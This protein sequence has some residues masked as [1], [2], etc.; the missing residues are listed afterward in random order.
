MEAS[1]R[2]YVIVYLYTLVKHVAVCFHGDRDS[3]GG[4]YKAG[5]VGKQQTRPVFSRAVRDSLQAAEVGGATQVLVHRENAR[6]PAR[7]RMEKRDPRFRLS[8]SWLRLC[9]AGR[10]FVACRNRCYLLRL[11]DLIFKTLQN[12]MKFFRLFDSLSLLLSLSSCF[13]F[14]YFVFWGILELVRFPSFSW[15]LL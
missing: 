4:C 5:P 11:I 7:A 3:R 14:I 8:S 9:G 2:S 12:C 6:W 15:G 1:C 13:I 10:S